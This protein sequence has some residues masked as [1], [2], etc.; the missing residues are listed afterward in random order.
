MI[1]IATSFSI[2]LLLIVVERVAREIINANFNLGVG[3]EW[4]LIPGGNLQHC[5]GGLGW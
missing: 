3:G 4:R 1:A 5:V 2:D